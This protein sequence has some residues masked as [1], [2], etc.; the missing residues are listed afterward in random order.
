MKPCQSLKVFIF[1]DRKILFFVCFDLSCD[2][3]LVQ[4]FVLIFNQSLVKW[5]GQ[6]IDTG[7]TVRCLEFPCMPTCGSFNSGLFDFLIGRGAHHGRHSM[8]LLFYSSTWR[9]KL[10]I[11]CQF[12]VR[13]CFGELIATYKL[14]IRNVYFCMYRGPF[15]IK[16]KGIPNSLELFCWSK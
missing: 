13:C 11:S 5:C 14:I 8:G 6:G 10:Y 4:C 9:K 15:V 3:V 7:N 16:G 1:W 12:S 2:A